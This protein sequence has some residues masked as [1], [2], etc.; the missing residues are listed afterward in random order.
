MYTKV[1]FGDHEHT[2]LVQRTGGGWLAVV[3]K[4]P[5]ELCDTRRSSG[6]HPENGKPLEV[7]S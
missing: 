6:H 5:C 1:K 7:H 2:V 3:Q 4:L